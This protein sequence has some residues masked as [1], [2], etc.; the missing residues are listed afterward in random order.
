MRAE[1]RRMVN[2]LDVAALDA[3]A[4]LLKENPQGG[5]VTFHSTTTPGALDCV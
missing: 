4:S 5:R 3:L 1:E 2:G